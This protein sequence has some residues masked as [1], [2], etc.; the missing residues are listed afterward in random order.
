MGLVL[1]AMLWQAVAV[2]IV[3]QSLSVIAQSHK[4]RITRTKY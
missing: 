1:Q 2:D 3:V 4:I